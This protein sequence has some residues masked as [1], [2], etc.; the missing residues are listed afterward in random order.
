MSGQLAD[1][2]GAYPGFYS[3]KRL[4]VFLFRHWMVCWS[5]ASRLSEKPFVF[6]I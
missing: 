2:A 1:T 3:T 5:I 6:I 4:G